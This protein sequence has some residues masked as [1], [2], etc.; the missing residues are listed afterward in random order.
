M[1][2][3]V[4]QSQADVL[5]LVT[6]QEGYMQSTQLVEGTPAYKCHEATKEAASALK[7]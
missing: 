6:F 1:E 4:K 7:V 2:S 5:M 3:T